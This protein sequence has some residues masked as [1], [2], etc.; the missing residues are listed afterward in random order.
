MVTPVKILF[1]L[2]DDETWLGHSTETVNADRLNEHRYRIQNTPFFKNG[3]SFQDII[4]GKDLGSEIVFKRVYKRGG[5]S[6]Y[7]L[8][9]A[10]C[11]SDSKFTEYWNPIQDLGAS[12]ESMS[13][14]TKAGGIQTLFAIDIPPSTDIINAYGALEKGERDKVWS[15]EE[16]HCG[17]VKS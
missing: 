12:Y 17:H 15:F 3:V 9:F 11:V 4:V 8:L 6:T 5:H 13:Y 2:V 14:K 1:E 7:R 10:G 16:G